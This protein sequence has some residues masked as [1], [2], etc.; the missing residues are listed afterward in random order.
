MMKS[1]RCNCPH[2]WFTKVLRILAGVSAI[3]FLWTVWKS[4]LVFGFSSGIWF[5]HFIVFSLMVVGM[6]GG[7]SC[8]CGDKHCT[9]CP[10]DMKKT[11]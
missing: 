3:L 5:E 8:C 7:C 10:V 6:K 11:M 1:D 9:T 4:T 2:H